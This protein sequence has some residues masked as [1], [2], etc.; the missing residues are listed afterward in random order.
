MVAW[1][2]NDGGQDGDDQKLAVWEQGKSHVTVDELAGENPNDPVPVKG[3]RQ[4]APPTS[5][6]LP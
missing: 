6:R 1:G 2:G 5:T 3:V 4:L